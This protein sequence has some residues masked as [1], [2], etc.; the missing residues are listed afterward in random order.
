M[1]KKIFK[2]N[3]FELTNTCTCN[4]GSYR[5]GSKTALELQGLG[6]LHKP[7]DKV[8]KYVKNVTSTFTMFFLAFICYSIIATFA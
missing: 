5:G 1:V 4:A 8:A 3:A 7:I 2:K 6:S